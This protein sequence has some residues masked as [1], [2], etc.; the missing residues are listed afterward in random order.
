MTNYQ[1]G[2]VRLARNLKSIPFPSRMNADM[3]HEVID[4]VWEALSSSALKDTLSIIHSEECDKVALMALSE[5]HLIS[6]DF[7]KGTLPRA[8]IISKDEKI[9]I[10]INEEDHIRIQVFADGNSLDEAYDTADKIDNLLAEK[11]DI[12][13][14]EKFGFLTA[15]PTNSG[16]GMRAS[17]MLHLPALTMSNSISSV[18]TWANKLG[19]AVRGIYGEGSKAKGA[20]YQLSNQITLGATEKDIIQRVNLAADELLKKEEMVRNTLFE[21]NRVRMTDRCMRSYGILTNAYALSSEEAFS[22]SSDVLLGISLGIIN[23]ITAQKLSDTLFSTLP[24]SI[25]KAGEFSDSDPTARDVLRAQKF[26]EN[27]K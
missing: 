10:M 16:T 26:R 6:P 8:V 22:F 17:F 23:N 19:L 12:A 3:A 15:C 13:F 14:H 27:L 25:T 18:L 11:L 9:S 24:A 21:N 5:K 20:F 1:S 4:K 2:R 7:L